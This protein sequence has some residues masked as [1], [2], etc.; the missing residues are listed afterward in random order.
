MGFVWL[1]FVLHK[2]EFSFQEAALLTG[3]CVKISN[4]IFSLDLQHMRGYASGM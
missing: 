4:G 2:L 1:I 3:S